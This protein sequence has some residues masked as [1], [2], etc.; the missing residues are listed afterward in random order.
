MKMDVLT[1]AKIT[2]DIDTYVSKSTTKHAFQNTLVRQVPQVLPL[3]IH[4]A[5][6]D[7]YL[8]PL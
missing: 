6:V 4:L 1:K 5:W 7:G 3:E 2:V 8:L